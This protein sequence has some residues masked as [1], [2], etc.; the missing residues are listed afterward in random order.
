MRVIGLIA[1]A[2][3]LYTPAF[4][5]KPASASA[6]KQADPEMRNKRAVSV[7]PV[8]P[9]N[10]VQTERSHYGAA[11]VSKS[12]SSP[13][14]E[15]AKIEQ[16]SV[17]HIKANPKRNASLTPSSQAV[18]GKQPSTR[19]KPIKFS[20]QPPKTAVKNSAKNPSSPGARSRPAH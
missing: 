3:V 1:L 11:S 8:R 10:S 12:G 18:T 17:H 7:T 2:A 13:A 16:S 6:Q 14:R 5:Q 9:R 19:N 15:L 20:Y 4:A